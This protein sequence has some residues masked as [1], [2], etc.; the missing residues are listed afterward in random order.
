MLLEIVSDNSFSGDRRRIERRRIVAE[1][2]EEGGVSGWTGPEEEGGDSGMV[3]SSVA[4]QW[5]KG[6]L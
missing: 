5:W 6:H 1:E 2:G 3:W 4:E